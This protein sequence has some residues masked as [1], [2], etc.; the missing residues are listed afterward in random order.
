MRPDFDPYTIEKC[1]ELLKAAYDLEEDNVDPEAVMRM[2]IFISVLFA[3]NSGTT[4]E[5]YVDIIKD[6][7][8]RMYLASEEFEEEDT[9]DMRD[10]NVWVSKKPITDEEQ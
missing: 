9:E 7:W 10:V 2:S 4:P 5:S 8:A 6:T 3:H 1:K